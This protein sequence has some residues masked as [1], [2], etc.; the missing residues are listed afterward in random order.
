MLDSPR[1]TQQLK[2]AA[3]GAAAAFAAVGVIA[4]RASS[5]ASYTLAG[6][7]VV[8]HREFLGAESRRLAMPSSVGIDSTNLE[9]AQKFIVDVTPTVHMNV[10]VCFGC[11]GIEVDQGYAEIHLTDAVGMRVGRINVPV[12]EFNVRHDPA[13]YTTPSKPLPY[14]MG[15][16]LHYQP[17]A[18]NLGV[19]PTPYS[20]NGV[21][22]FGSLWLLGKIQLDYALYVVKGLAGTNDLDFVASRRY[23]DNNRTPAVGT[24]WVATVGPLSVGGS[25]GGGFYDRRDRLKYL[26]Y[27]AEAYLRLDPLVFRGEIIYRLTDYDPDAPGY[28]FA[29]VEPYFLKLG[30]YGQADWNLTDWLTLVYRVDGLSRMGMPLPGT[31]IDQVFTGIV[32]HTGAAAFRFDGNLLL[33]VGYEYWAFSGVPFENQHVARLALVYSY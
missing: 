6:S 10:K 18:F 33:K 26:F 19:V 9:L 12:G 13:N 5:A 3:L 1:R 2:G 7:A 30:Y 4:P 8:D 28:R 21:E 11:H 22:V 15:D 17:D 29:P 23:T 24:R 32:R 25:I 27:G 14:A 16:M 31:Q 20:D